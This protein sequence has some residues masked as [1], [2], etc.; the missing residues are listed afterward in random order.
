M[1][2]CFLFFCFFIL[3]FLRYIPTWWRYPRLDTAI[4]YLK[5]HR[6]VGQ[7]VKASASRAADPGFE[8]RL[9][10]YLSGS[11]HTSDLKIGTPV[12]TMPGAWRHRVS[13]GTGRPG[14]SILRL[15]EMDSLICTFHISVAARIVCLIRSVPEIR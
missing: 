11:S 15:G 3:P 2:D 10:R 7:V 6:L 13:S 4:I 12:A 5:T 14:V 9:L 1:C 8:S